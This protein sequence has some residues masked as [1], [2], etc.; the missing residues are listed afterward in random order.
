[1]ASSLPPSSLPR[2]DYIKCQHHQTLKGEIAMSDECCAL[3]TDDEKQILLSTI[4]HSKEGKTINEI[5]QIIYDSTGQRWG[6]R[7]TCECL[8]ILRDRGLIEKGDGGLMNW[9]RK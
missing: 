9:R 2:D 5:R 6:L 3:L 7:G 4:D 1:M 8:N